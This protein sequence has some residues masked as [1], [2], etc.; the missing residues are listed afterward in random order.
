MQ[1]KHYSKE[2]NNKTYLSLR[3]TSSFDEDIV[4]LI[5]KTQCFTDADNDSSR[6][7]VRIRFWKW[8]LELQ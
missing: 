1:I 2:F 7:L 8:M 5:Y 6:I 4:G 3:L